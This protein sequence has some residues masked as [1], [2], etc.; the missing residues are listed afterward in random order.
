M[1]EDVVQ[2]IKRTFPVRFDMGT[3]IT[4]ALVCYNIVASLTTSQG[5]VDELGKR[6][7][8]IEIRM[9]AVQAEQQHAAVSIAVLDNKLDTKH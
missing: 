9:E 6:I 2:Q 4:A 1:A 7:E 3:L 8:K 5:H